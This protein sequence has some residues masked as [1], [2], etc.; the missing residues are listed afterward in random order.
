MQSVCS[1]TGLKYGSEKNRKL[2]H[3]AEVMIKNQMSRFSRHCVLSAF[4]RAKNESHTLRLHNV[5]RRLNS[6]YRYYKI[7]ELVF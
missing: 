4:Q 2:F 3:A 6:K 5:I 7:F 1:L